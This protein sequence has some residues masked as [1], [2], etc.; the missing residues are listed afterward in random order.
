MWK[1]LKY[2]IK[3][4]S[5]MA[6]QSA[7][8]VKESDWRLVILWE[9]AAYSESKGWTLMITVMNE[10][11]P[12]SLCPAAIAYASR[13]VSLG[14]HSTILCIFAYN[15]ISNLHRMNDIAPNSASLYKGEH[16]KI[17]TLL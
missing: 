13:G 17:H 14:Q 11:R 6:R 16:Y 15:F 7:A 9:D 2:P 8:Q 4:G 12:L 3:K 5:F 1:G 10:R